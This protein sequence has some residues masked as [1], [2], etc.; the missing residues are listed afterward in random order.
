MRLPFFREGDQ[1]LLEDPGGAFP[2][3]IGEVVY[4]TGAD[5]VVEWVLRSGDEGLSFLK[6]S[7]GPAH[8][9]LQGVLIEIHEGESDRNPSFHTLIGIR[10]VAVAIH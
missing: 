6:L 1:L 7:F 10:I 2:I 4:A 9:L 5:V 3:V 8:S